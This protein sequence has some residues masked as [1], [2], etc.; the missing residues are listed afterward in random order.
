M[1]GSAG[2]LSSLSHSTNSY[3]ERRCLHGCAD[4]ASPRAREACHCTH[5]CT[6]PASPRAHTG[7][8]TPLS[9]SSPDPAHHS[10]SATPAELQS[11]GFKAPPVPLLPVHF[12]LGVRG[13]VGCPHC[14]SQAPWPE[15]AARLCCWTPQPTAL[16]RT[17]SLVTA[18]HG[19]PVLGQNFPNM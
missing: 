7:I 3:C 11:S 18:L 2:A 16:L 14:E 1:L 17:F 8:Q 5:G 9:C 13:P 15:L 10:A 12:H 6:D 19:G 4:P